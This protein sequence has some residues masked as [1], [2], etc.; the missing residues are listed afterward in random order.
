MAEVLV[1]DGIL[2]ASRLWAEILDKYP[3]VAVPSVVYSPVP[4]GISGGNQELQEYQTPLLGKEL[5]RGR[6]PVLGRDMNEIG[7]EQRSRTQVF[8]VGSLVY[9]WTGEGDDPALESLRLWTRHLIYEREH[10]LND[11]KKTGL[12]RP[13]AMVNLDFDCPNT[14]E[15]RERIVR[16]LEGH[17]GYADWAVLNSGGS[18]YGVISGLV[19][20]GDLPWHYGRLIERFAETGTKSATH[21]FQEFGRSLQKA[22]GDMSK[23]ERFCDDVARI[24]CHYDDPIAKGR[25]FIIDLKWMKNSLIEWMRF[26]RTGSGGFAYV[27]VSDKVGYPAPPIIVAR[28]TSGGPTELFDIGGTFDSGQLRLPGI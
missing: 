26:M 15:N 28:H 6:W 2:T 18:F 13:K 5:S 11:L 22:H 7:W 12:L 9:V 20:V 8:A 3:I 21:V 27:R 19:E 14:G 10:S 24:I 17:Y 25:P 1:Q 16:V 23:V 4:H